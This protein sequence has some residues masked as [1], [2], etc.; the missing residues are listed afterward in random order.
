LLGFQTAQTVGTVTPD[1]IE[2]IAGD[3]V[4]AVPDETA[5]LRD[6]YL[7][8]LKADLVLYHRLITAVFPGPKGVDGSKE[9]IPQMTG[10]MT[11]S[12]HR[13]CPP[14]VKKKAQDAPITLASFEGP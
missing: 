7:M 3:N 6:R 1:V 12:K 5:G 14:S 2:D 10:E 4:S 9:R 11:T 8:R 13:F